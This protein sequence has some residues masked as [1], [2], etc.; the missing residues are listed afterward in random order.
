MVQG[1]AFVFITVLWKYYAYLVNDCV[2]MTR[3]LIG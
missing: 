2:S 1:R 3:I